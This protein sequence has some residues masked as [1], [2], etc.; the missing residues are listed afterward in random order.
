MHCE[1]CGKRG[2]DTDVNVWEPESGEWLGV[3]ALCWN[4]S[5]AHYA[6]Y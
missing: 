6:G 1:D 4:C 3:R 2:I 5:T